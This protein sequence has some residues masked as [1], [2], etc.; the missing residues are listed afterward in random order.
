MNIAET[1]SPYIIIA[2]TCG[3][4]NRHRKVTYSFVDSYHSLCHDKRDII[5]SEIQACE[6]LLKYAKGE[7]DKGAVEKE[8]DELRMIL[9]FIQ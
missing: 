5:L 9:D 2:K 6:R 1:E 8:I 4:T 7:E 3:C